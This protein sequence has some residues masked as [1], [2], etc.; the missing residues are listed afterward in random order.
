MATD[1]SSIHNDNCIQAILSSQV[2]ITY[3]MR[4]EEELSKVC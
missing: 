1:I 4:I 3:N 2:E